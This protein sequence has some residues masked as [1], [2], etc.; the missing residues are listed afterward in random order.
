M[1]ASVSGTG[2]RKLCA[3]RWLARTPALQDVLRAYDAL[4]LCF[5]DFAQ[6][7]GICYAKA[8][9]IAVVLGKSLSYLGIYVSLLV[10][11]RAEQVFRRLQQRGIMLKAAMDAVSELREYY[12]PLHT[13]E[14]WEEVWQHVIS[15]SVEL[16]LESPQLTRVRRPPR[17]LKQTTTVTAPCQFNNVK[18]KHKIHYLQLIDLLVAELDRRFDQPGMS[19]LLVI[20]R[21]LTGKAEPGDVSTIVSTY[22]HF[23]PCISSLLRHLKSLNELCSGDQSNLSDVFNKLRDVHA[24]KLDVLFKGAIMLACIYMACPVTSV[25]CERS[26]SVMRRLKTWLR[27]ATGQSRLNHE[28]LLV[29]HSARAVNIDDV[30]HDFVSLNEQRQDD[31]GL[32]SM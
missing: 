23:I 32:Y 1:S 12:V 24:K 14:T 7:S 29:I 3:T 31:L 10:F 25:E 5:E 17:K 15:K 26:F 20:E 4:Q 6:S 30:I 22:K 11:R 18:T 16:D 13:D 19:K 8:N 9:G 2:V 27:R 21:I 28:L